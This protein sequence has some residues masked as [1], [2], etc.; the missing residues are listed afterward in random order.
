MRGDYNRYART[1][2][3]NKKYGRAWKR[4]RDRYAA[5]HP[6]CERCL[7]KG[8]DHLPDPARCRPRVRVHAGTLLAAVAAMGKVMNLLDFMG[9]QS[10]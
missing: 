1:P 3:S 2:D 5:A 6:L 9:I 4:I 7:K 8:D 10:E